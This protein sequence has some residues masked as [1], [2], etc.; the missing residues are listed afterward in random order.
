MNGLGA[1]IPCA[2]IAK[3]RS[4]TGRNAHFKSARQPEAGMERGRGV[5]PT[6][7]QA[8]MPIPRAPVDIRRVSQNFCCKFAEQ[9]PLACIN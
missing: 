2:G 5:C 4:A 9:R 3:A 7:A 1:T 8:R 6:K